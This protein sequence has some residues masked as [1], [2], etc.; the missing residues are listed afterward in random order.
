MSMD[1]TFILASWDDSPA[2]ELSLIE[3]RLTEIGFRRMTGVVR[4][5]Y[6]K[7]RGVFDEADEEEELSG[8]EFISEVLDQMVYWDG[9]AV[10]FGNGEFSFYLLVGQVEGGYLN[11]WIDIH[12]RTLRRLFASETRFKLYAGVCAVGAGCGAVGGY[13]DL[14]LAFEPI[15]PEKVID[16]IP[17]NPQKPGAASWFGMI[18]LGVRSEAEVRQAFGDDYCITGSSGG[19]W[20]LEAK[21]FLN[22]FL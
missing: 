10:E 1:F 17:N 21:E 9:A 8:F 2:K 20:I 14:E 4:A 3:P 18:P 12:E 19:F 16:A 5:E 6:D 22:M 15:R 7:Q 11:Y 13:G